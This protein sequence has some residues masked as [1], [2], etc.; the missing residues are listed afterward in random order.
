M[1][2]MTLNWYKS[3][4]NRTSVREFSDTVD[5]K[6]FTEL[7]KFA[8]G[9]NNDEARLVL[10]SK[11]G[12]LKS[13][14]LAYGRVAGTKGFAAVIT[15]K[16]SKYM[17]GYIGEAFVLECTARGIATCWLGAS[18]KKS[19]VRE[20]VDIKEDETLACIIAFGFYDGKVKHTK[21]KSIEQ[22][23]GLNAAAFRRF[24]H[25]S[26][27]LS[28]AHGFRLRLSISSRGSLI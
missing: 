12:V 16:G 14:F 2:D 27:R 9:L 7:K 1:N 21:K 15:K 17:G 25:G 22:L 6:T 8:A 26:R 11:D 20:F 28:T 13:I 3:I 5:Q 23:T 18:Y 24:R 10:R 4:K 19:K